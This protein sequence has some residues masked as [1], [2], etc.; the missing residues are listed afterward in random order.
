M[1]WALFAIAAAVSTSVNSILE[2]RLLKR[3]TSLELSVSIAIFGFLLTFP[4]AWFVPYD[5]VTPTTVAVIFFGTLL[6]TVAYLFATKGLRHMDISSFDPLM[7]L[8]PAVTAVA[9]F[10]VLDEP[11]S[12]MQVAGLVMTV[13]GTYVL[14]SHRHQR[15][16]DPIRALVRSRYAHFVFLVL[17]I[18]AI[19][20]LI[21][22]SSLAT[23]GYH[24]LT[25]ILLVH[26]F[27][28]L[29]C[30]AIVFVVGDGA[31]E[32]RRAIRK[33]GW[34]LVPVSILT[35]LTR[36]F[37]AYAAKGA[38]IGIVSALKRTASFFTTLIGG[39]LFHE[40][41]LAR[42]ALASL[43]IIAGVAVIVVS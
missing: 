4:L 21:D 39:E 25:Y 37:Y 1:I 11:L 27:F 10:V 32:F 35:V 20:S 9:A 29:H 17:L 38:A 41:N 43:M 24:P 5:G 30:T 14:E 7:N 26:L 16:L 2:K 13:L 36:T 15:A 23:F 42:K 12:R 18:H 6:G 22:R 31:E 33:A 8:G 28:G 34:S 40:K 3:I 19:T